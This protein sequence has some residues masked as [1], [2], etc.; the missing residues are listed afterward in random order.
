MLAAIRCMLLNM[1]SDWK[2]LA[3][4]AAEGRIVVERVALPDKDLHLEGSFELPPLARLSLE[5][6]VF[7]A[8]FVKSHG[9]IK[10]MERLFGVSYPT[11]K[12][13][14]NRLAQQLDPELS[15]S[16]PPASERSEVL[17]QLERGDISVRQAVEA[18]KK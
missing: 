6:Q 5:D 15:V 7:V 18:L 10:E 4:I 17:D 11:I 9:S 14:L 2:D 13:R 8:A 3:L 16:A 1:A 12:G